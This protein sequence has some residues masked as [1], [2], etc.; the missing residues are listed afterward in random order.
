MIDF[1]RTVELEGLIIVYQMIEEP[2]LEKIARS[3]QNRQIENAKKIFELIQDP[4]VYLDGEKEKCT[5]LLT[6][7]EKNVPEKFSTIKSYLAHLGVAEYG[8]DLVRFKL[9]DSYPAEYLVYDGRHFGIGKENKF[10]ELH[11]EFRITNKGS[12]K[13]CSIF[14]CAYKNFLTSTKVEG[15]MRKVFRCNHDR[16]KESY[17][18]D[19]YVDEGKIMFRPK[20]KKDQEKTD[21]LF[22]SRDRT[23]IQ[24]F[25]KKEGAG[26]ILEVEVENLKDGNWETE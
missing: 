17:G 10:N 8:G 19:W 11:A 25:Q 5:N 4:F 2:G 24:F 18:N 26:K 22:L 9:K 23:D 7:I 6:F 15:G 12:R 14:S 13:R 16:G 3:N 20:K 1:L 21:E